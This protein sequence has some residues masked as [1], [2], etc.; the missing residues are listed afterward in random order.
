[1]G[2][3]G[4]MTIETSIA[5]L[6]Q[7][8]GANVEAACIALRDSGSGLDPQARAHLFE[9][10]FS[11]KG[12]GRGLGLAT[13]W[14]F[15]HQSGGTID[16]ESSR[17]GT[18]VRLLFPIASRAAGDTPASDGPGLTIVPEAPRPPRTVLVAEDEPSVRKS[19]RVF[20]ER[21]G[22]TVVDAADGVDALAAF[23]RNPDEFGLL[24][25]DVMMPQMGGRELATKVMERRPEI[26]IVFMSGF[27]RDPEVLRMVNDRRV[28][29]LAKPF[30]IDLLVSTV[31]G[32]LGGAKADV[33]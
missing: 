28:R 24:L 29:F 31:S 6:P 33:A 19:V 27:L 32:E 5:L 14:A 10:F 18:T 23:E 15:V 22:F 3:T 21:A 17:Q 11:T 25:T 4:T 20:L 9:P 30:D 7:Q 2:E 1:M 26:P 12:D 13:T 8:F 16:I